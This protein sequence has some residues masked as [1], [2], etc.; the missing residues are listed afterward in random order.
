[1]KDKIKQSQSIV[2]GA[3]SAQ[4][5]E[6]DKVNQSFLQKNCLGAVNSGIGANDVESIV[7]GSSVQPKEDELLLEIAQAE[8]QK[9]ASG[10]CEIAEITVFGDVPESLVFSEHAT[11]KLFRRSTKREYFINGKM[12]E[13]R[14]G[15]DNAL[16]QKVKSRAACAFCLGDYIA[17]FVSA[18]RL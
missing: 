17:V 15:L 14:I 11:Y 5:C 8:S 7:F 10:S 13:A 4:Q 18:R 6:F 3:K 16:Y 1:M 12:L 9:S 2:T